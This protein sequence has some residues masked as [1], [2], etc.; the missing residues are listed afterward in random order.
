MDANSTTRPL[1]DNL[2]LGPA[3][4]IV[5]YLLL[6]ISGLALIARLSTKWAVSHR[7]NLDDIL[8]GISLIFVIGNGIGTSFEASNGL[9]SPEDYTSPDRLDIAQKALFAAEL[10]F[11]ASLCLSKL[12]AIAFLRHLT[13]D[14]RY[15]R[16]CLWYGIFTTLWSVIALV[17]I[18]F[19][20]NLPK[21]WLILGDKCINRTVF[22]TIFLILE[23]FL[24]LLLILIPLIIMW[25]LR[26]SRMQKV[27]LGCCFGFRIVVV[28]ALIVQ[29][30][31]LGQAFAATDFIFHSWKATLLS[32]IVLCL[33]YV[34][35]CVPYLRPFLES[36][37]SGM[38]RNE[39]I[40]RVG[41]VESGSNSLANSLGLNRLSNK[42]A[43]SGSG[44]GSYGTDSGIGS[45]GTKASEERWYHQKR[46][47]AKTSM[48]SGT[49]QSKII[50]KTTSITWVH[51]PENVV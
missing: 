3:V 28:A 43:K 12:S 34:A 39:P 19:Q 18:A 35:P 2:H 9:G 20:C 47:G 46:G 5:T 23:I 44:S 14:S 37:D 7:M 15:M 33:S 45:M 32:E 26:V 40:R 49:S 30:V 41:Q 22:W 38:L 21:V 36:L 13:P 17:V 51:E 10:C 11:I 31:F 48:E 50:K 16:M 29:V 1:V 4:N 25:R 6:V 42:F 27:A 24:N 8:I